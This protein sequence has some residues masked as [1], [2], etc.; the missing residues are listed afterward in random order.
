VSLRFRSYQH[1]LPIL[2]RLP[3]SLWLLSLLSILSLHSLSQTP[4][5]TNSLPS[6]H[7]AILIHTATVAHSRLPTFP[8]ESPDTSAPAPTMEQRIAWA[9]LTIPEFRE[10]YEREGVRVDWEEVRRVAWG[11]GGGR[12][13]DG[14]DRKTESRHRRRAREEIERRRGGGSWMRRLAKL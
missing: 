11:H 3:S 10:R 9:V 12:G 8:V 1:V 13:Q 7:S 14:K 4:S 5:P 2:L 6:S